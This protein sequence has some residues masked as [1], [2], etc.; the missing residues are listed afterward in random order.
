VANLRHLSRRITSPATAFWTEHGERLSAAG[1]TVMS[2]AADRPSWVERRGKSRV[3][4]IGILIVSIVAS[5][6]FLPFMNFAANRIVE[7]E[8]YSILKALPLTDSILLSGILAFATAT[9][10]L[11]TPLLLRLGA[12]AGA[13]L[14]LMVF[15][16]LAADQLMEHA[17]SFA[18]VSTGGGFWLLLLAFSLALADGL[19]RLRSGPLVRIMLL[20]IG[21]ASLWLLLASGLWNNQSILKEYANQAPAFWREA[22]QHMLLA[23]GSVLLA[24]LVGIPAGIACRPFPRI[25]TALL[26]ALTFIQTIPSIAL[27]GLLIAPLSWLAANHAWTAALGVSGIGTAPAMVALFAYSLLPV[28][29]N[30]VAGLDSVPASAR[31]AARGMGMTPAQRLRQVELPLAFPVVLAGIRIVLVQ[32]IGLATIAALIGGGG[33]G[34]FVFQGISQMAMDLV[35]LGTVPT[36]ILAFAAA[37][38]MDALIDLY[39]SPGGGR[40]AE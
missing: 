16:G 9:L 21:L 8:A 31:E 6:V 4:K 11:R 27:F 19:T 13:I 40:Q 36:I 30:T 26:N 32:N 20:L 29:A 37:V 34:V 12:A 24:C 35:L 7:G 33:F 2:F 28:V 1:E 5:A 23:S 14:A 10:L 15:A 17:N 39:R 3:D 18:R 38:L 25:R 22:R